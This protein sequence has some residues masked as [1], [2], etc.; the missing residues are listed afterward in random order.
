MFYWS[1]GLIFDKMSSKDS[2]N[3][4]VGR[5]IDSFKGMKDVEEKRCSESY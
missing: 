4:K 2:L 5:W 3:N 1:L